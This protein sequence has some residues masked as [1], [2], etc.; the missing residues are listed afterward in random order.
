MKI[1]TQ[2]TVSQVF[3][4][5]FSIYDLDF[6][7]ETLYKMMKFVTATL[8]V[9]LVRSRVLRVQNFRLYQQCHVHTRRDDLATLID[10]LDATLATSSIERR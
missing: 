5:T 2:I 3:H 1:H 7:G 9:S 4:V 10:E 6:V 8:E